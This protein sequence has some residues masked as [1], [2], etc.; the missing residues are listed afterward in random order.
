[1]LFNQKE[2]WAEKNHKTT[3][4]NFF[5]LQSAFAFNKPAPNT[6][7]TIYQQQPKINK[8]LILGAEDKITEVFH[9]K[10]KP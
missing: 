8:S 2:I 9:Q 5:H 3:L 6:T 10:D 4:Y 1:M 7:T